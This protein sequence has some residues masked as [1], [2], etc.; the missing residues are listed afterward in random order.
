MTEKTVEIA[1]QK[2]ETLLEFIQEHNIAGDGQ[3]LGQRFVNCFISQ[4]WPE[5]FHETSDKEALKIIEKWLTD[6][7]YFDKM[8]TQSKRNR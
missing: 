2:A 4:P 1:G 8:P 5:L 7:Q 6:H 3:R